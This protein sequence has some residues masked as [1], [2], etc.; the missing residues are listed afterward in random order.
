MTNKT[1]ENLSKTANLIIKL[2]QNPIP[3]DCPLCG[4][5]TNP[6][7]GA[8]LF[9]ADSDQ[10]VCFDCGG[11]FSP[12]LAC[13]ITFANIARDFQFIENPIIADYLTF[14]ELSKITAQTE[15]RFGEIWA[16][17]SSFIKSPMNSY[18]DFGAEVA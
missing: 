13:L 16:N 10:I 15:N 7:I 6:N 12:V 14:A 4:Q 3:N 5:L 1:L 17:E 11:N 2:N 18:Q 9:L 8:E